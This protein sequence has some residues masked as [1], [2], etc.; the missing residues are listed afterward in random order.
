MSR[1]S[2][3]NNPTDDH[4]KLD[5][6][7]LEAKDRMCQ[8]GLN[9]RDVCYR[10]D[11]NELVYLLG[12]MDDASMDASSMTITVS[13]SGRRQVCTGGQVP[14][15][16][17]RCNSNGAESTDN[18]IDTSSSGS[19]TSSTASGVREGSDNSHVPGRPRM[20]QGGFRGKRM[21]QE[22]DLLDV[23]FRSTRPCGGRS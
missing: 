23:V 1:S 16:K 10:K 12:K 18:A 13:T 8:C 15:K 11:F 17:G 9:C 20:V 6:Y 3:A 4:R 7:M 22:K 5:L 2:H 19:R 14:Q 21:F